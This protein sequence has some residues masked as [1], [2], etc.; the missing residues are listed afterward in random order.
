M[1]SVTMTDGKP[2][3]VYTLLLLALIVLVFGRV[4]THDSVNL[5][6][7]PL[8]F[9]NPHLVPPTLDGMAWH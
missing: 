3:A 8:I 1:L 6:D 5:D 9:A 7:D 2:R 4:V